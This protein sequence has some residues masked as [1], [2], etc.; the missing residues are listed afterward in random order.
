MLRYSKDAESFKIVALGEGLEEISTK[1]DRWPEA[2]DISL[3]IGYLQKRLDQSE[4]ND[5]LR[6]PAAD[7]SFPIGRKHKSLLWLDIDAKK[8]KYRTAAGLI[9]ATHPSHDA[10]D[11]EK[12]VKSH[13]EDHEES[14]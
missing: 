3:E 13:P 2:R 9:Y 14:V 8:E 5:P 10:K 11:A 7:G 12:Q 4:C 1:L 6:C